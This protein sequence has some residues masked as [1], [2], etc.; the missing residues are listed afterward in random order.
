MGR[1]SDLQIYKQGQKPKQFTVNVSY[2]TIFYFCRRIRYCGLFVR[3]L[4]N[5]TMFKKNDTT[6]SGHLWIT[7]LVKVVVGS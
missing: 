3:L 4:T 5:E 6:C 7:S 1:E 2:N